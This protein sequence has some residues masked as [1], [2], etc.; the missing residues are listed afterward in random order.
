MGGLGCVITV[1]IMVS[2]SQTDKQADLLRKELCNKLIDENEGAIERHSV[3]LLP[4]LM[5]RQ[6]DRKTNEE[7]NTNKCSR[8][9][10][11]VMFSDIIKKGH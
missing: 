6:T 4:K 11:K 3:I 1:V 5:E 2:L 10:Q 8:M 9:C 7:R